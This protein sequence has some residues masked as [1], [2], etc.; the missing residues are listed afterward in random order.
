MEITSASQQKLDF[1]KLLVT[2]LQNQNPLDPMDNQQ[3]AAQL[4]QFTQL[5]LSE[6]MNNNMDSMNSTMSEMNT[7]F[8]GAMLL[9][10]LEYARSMLGQEVSFYN[11]QYDQMVTGQVAKLT[12]E[13]NEP[14]LV[15]NGT[16]THNDTSTSEQE[17]TIRVSDVQGIKL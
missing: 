6:N 13:N 12:I 4:A 14:M 3:M 9:A 10:Q 11:S 7:S 16:V 1:M 2:E 15:V 17:F 5:E 8:M